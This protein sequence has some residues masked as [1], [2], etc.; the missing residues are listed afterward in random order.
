VYNADANLDDYV[1]WA[2]GFTERANDKRIA[3]VH[4]NGLVEFKGMLPPLALQ[5]PIH[6]RYTYL[7]LDE[8]DILEQTFHKLDEQFS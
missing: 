3:I 1:A 6:W 2:G 4:A 8:L 7:Q 5:L